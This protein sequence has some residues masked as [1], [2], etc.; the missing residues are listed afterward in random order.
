MEAGKSNSPPPDP[1]LMI[2]LCSDEIVH[3]SGRDRQIGSIAFDVDGCT[4]LSPLTWLMVHDMRRKYE[5][6]RAERGIMQDACSVVQSRN[7]VIDVAPSSF[8]D[9]PLLSSSEFI[10]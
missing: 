10:S 1:L 2:G 6:V 8:L 3:E 7:T 9:V 5:Y 4:I